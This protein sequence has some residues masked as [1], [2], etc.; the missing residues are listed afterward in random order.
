MELVAELREQRPALAIQGLGAPGIS[1]DVVGATQPPERGRANLGRS[2]RCGCEK[3]LEPGC[4]LPRRPDDPERL[5]RGCERK[6]CRRILDQRPLERGTDV[7]ELGGDQLR[8]PGAAPRDG[9]GEVGAI[10]ERHERRDLPP[11]QGGLAAGLREPGGRER[12]DRLEHPV[13]RR[14]VGIGSAPDEALVEERRERVEIRVTDLDRGVERAARSEDRKVGEELLLV[15]PE[16]IVRPGDRRL[17]GR[18]ARIR[19]T[20]ASQQVEPRADSLEQVL[21]RQ[22]LGARRRKLDGQ[23]QPVEALAERRHSGG[24]L[25]TTPDG[26]RSDEEQLDRLVELERRQVELELRPDP[27]RLS[28]G[29]DQAQRGRRLGQRRDRACGIG[30]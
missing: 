15:R 13:A 5:E 30:Q 16:E 27:E 22:E 25:E 12:A 3:A 7:V 6:T 28:A 14:P 1:H 29:D 24:C 26:L 21:G 2:S 20:D 10:R 23:R 11:A 9:G 8:P 18:V 4:P 17:E 19:V